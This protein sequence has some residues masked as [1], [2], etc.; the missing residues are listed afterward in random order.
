MVPRTIKPR[1]QRMVDMRKSPLRN[2]VFAANDISCNW[3][4]T[5][6]TLL[7]C[8][9]PEYIILYPDSWVENKYSGRGEE[10]SWMKGK[11]CTKKRCWKKRDEEE[12]A[13]VKKVKSDHYPHP[14]WANPLGC[15]F[16]KWLRAPVILWT[17][18]AL[19]NSLHMKVKR[20]FDSQ[21]HPSW[22]KHTMARLLFLRHS[23]YHQL[24]CRNV[25]AF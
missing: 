10:A 21:E 7:N 15:F 22:E 14:Q 23:F 18:S 9:L 20:Y 5:K 19:N 4:L 17:W 13:L 11:K 25:H 6:W 2:P 8:A 3:M 12:K 16:R 1:M 24:R